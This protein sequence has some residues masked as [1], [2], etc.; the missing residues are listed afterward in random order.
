MSNK[1]PA[2]IKAKKENNKNKKVAIKKQQNEYE[3]FKFGKEEIPEITKAFFV[4]LRYTIKKL[5]SSKLLWIITLFTS[6]AFLFT[7]RGTAISAVNQYVSFGVIASSYILAIIILMA[8]P[9]LCAFFM[10]RAYRDERDKGSLMFIVTKKDHKSLI[11][12]AKYIAAILVTWLW[13]FAY[14][15]GTLFFILLKI[16]LVMGGNKKII[17][18]LGINPPIDQLS[19]YIEVGVSMICISIAV[20]FFWASIFFLLSRVLGSRGVVMSSMMVPMS[21]IIFPIIGTLIVGFGGSLNSLSKGS[22]DSF[23]MKSQNT[24][25]IGCNMKITNM[26]GA[27][28][29]YRFQSNSEAVGSDENDDT[30]FSTWD[31]KTSTPKPGY[32]FGSNFNGIN[33]KTSDDFISACENGHNKNQNW[34]VSDV[35]TN[36]KYSTNQKDYKIIRTNNGKSKLSNATWSGLFG[37]RRFSISNTNDLISYKYDTQDLTPLTNNNKAG[38]LSFL[39]PIY[40]TS[41]LLEQPLKLIPGIDNDIIDLTKILSGTFGGKH[42]AKYFIDESTRNRYNKSLMP[43]RN[44]KNGSSFTP[45]EALPY[46]WVII[47]S[48]NGWKNEIEDFRGKAATWFFDVWPILDDDS[49]TFYTNELFIDSTFTLNYE[50]LQYWM[51][52]WMIS[53]VMISTGLLFSWLAIRTNSRHDISR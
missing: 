53:I 32:P 28:S 27:A 17:D 18:V 41:V 45:Y 40:Y 1:K 19:L 51:G 47:N 44:L 31:Y 21:A 15:A 12:F 29:N 25:R 24:Q 33:W 52:P 35:N 13:L 20:I 10:S 8:L 37:A 42:N 22:Y 48:S 5:T 4:H 7:W 9:I 23:E 46:D 30:Y 43:V 3:P 50:G 39:N 2:V 11:Y 14:F 34:Q 49:Y 38:W 26:S 16:L 6:V 36:W